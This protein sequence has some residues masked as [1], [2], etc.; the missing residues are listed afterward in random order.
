[1]C[2][3]YLSCIH[4]HTYTPAA[5]DLTSSHPHLPHLHLYKTQQEVLS[6]YFLDEVNMCCVLCCFLCVY[7]PLHAC[8]QHS[9]RPHY[10]CTNVQTLNP[11]QHPPNLPH[12][13]ETGGGRFQRRV[14]LRHR[15]QHAHLHARGRLRGGFGAHAAVPSLSSFFPPLCT[16][17]STR[18][19]ACMH[20]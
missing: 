13:T 6:E 10:K 15:A 17:Q 4:I 9:T 5:D 1:M 3:P 2:G 19:N 7:I 16:P 12:Q 11:E 8:T 18:L 14:P 20:A